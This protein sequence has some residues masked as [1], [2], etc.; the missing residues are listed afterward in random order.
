M[1]RI[2]VLG[3]IGPEATAEFYSKLIRRLQEKNL[4][5]SN[6]DF[7]QIIINSIPAPEL[8]Y[9]NISETDLKPYRK[10]LQELDNFHGDFIL[11]VCNT[12]HLYYDVLQREIRTPIL[13]LRKE[14]H[15]ELIKK[16]I[17]SVFV[18][19]T[20]STIKH[21]LYKFD[22]INYFEP[23]ESE[24]KQLTKSIFDFNRGFETG[25]CIDFVRHVCK[26]YLERGADIVILG[27]TEFALMLDKEKI[28]KINT[29]DVL[30][31]SAVDRFISLKYIS[32]KEI[33]R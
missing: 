2:G 16:G 22:N 8:I 11:M 17:K 5:K 7:P 31:N 9:D 23:D 13:D 28:P 20:P 32:G 19:G 18:I 1:T 14:I 21:G 12:I 26:K 15:N 33:T 29:I 30:V 3:G 25:G 6:V 4:I 10:G 24:M 27:C